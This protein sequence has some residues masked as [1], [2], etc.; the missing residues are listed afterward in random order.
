MKVDLK[1]LKLGKVKQKIVTKMVREEKNL[2]SLLFEEGEWGV[3]KV[4]IGSFCCAFFVWK[5]SLV[6]VTNGATLS[7]YKLW[8][9]NQQGQGN[10]CRTPGVKFKE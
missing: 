8:R 7:S 10:Q 6:Y 9:L 1:G 5:P 2:S 3:C 4:N